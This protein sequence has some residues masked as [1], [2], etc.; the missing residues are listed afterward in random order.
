MALPQI[1]LHTLAFVMVVAAIGNVRG[2]EPAGSSQDPVLPDLTEMTPEQ[3]TA[4]MDRYKRAMADAQQKLISRVTAEQKERM[5]QGSHPSDK[6]P[7]EPPIPQMGPNYDWELDAK[8]QGLDDDVRARLCRDSL[9]IAGQE[10]KQSFS[11]YD[12]ASAIP[13]VTSD[14]L[15]NGFHVLLEAT[16]K[17]FEV[18]RAVELREALESTWLGIDRS[19]AEERVPP[20]L[21][22]PYSRHLARVIGP[23][24]RL[25]GSSIA[26][27]DKATESDIDE[28]V[29]KITAAKSAELPGWMAPAEPALMAIDFRRCRPLGFYADLP[30]LADYYRAVRW[31][32]LVPLRAGRDNEAGAAALAVTAIRNSP[33]NL[34]EFVER[35]VKVWGREDKT[36][37]S[38]SEQGWPEFLR[39]IVKDGN[40]VQAVQEARRRIVDLAKGTKQEVNDRVRLPAGEEADPAVNLLAPTVLPDSQFLVSIAGS[41]PGDRLRPQGLEVAAWLGSD[42]A[43]DMLVQTSGAKL[44]EAIRA[45]RQGPTDQ[46]YWNATVPE[47]YYDV[48]RAVFAPPD[49]AAPPFM[50]SEAWHRKSTQT[51]LAGWAQLR[52]AWELQSEL[53]VYA[54]CAFDRPSGLVEPSPLFFRKMNSLE[55]MLVKRFQEA[56]VFVDT[57]DD[58]IE[59]LSDGLRT[60][61]RIGAGKV[62][63][64]MD[65]GR[66]DDMEKVF[67]LSLI[68]HDSDA[69][70]EVDRADE[71]HGETQKQ[72][73]S[74][75]IAVLSNRI[76]RLKKGERLPPVEEHWRK[77]D[78][79]QQLFERWQ[80]LQRL[81]GR[82][83]VMVQKQLRGADWDKDE[84]ELLKD[85]GSELKEIMGYFTNVSGMEQ[86]DAPRWTTVY[87]DMAANRNLAVA[88]GRPRALYVLYPWKGKPVLCRGAVMTY[89]EY[90]SEGRLTDLEWKKLLDSPAAPAQPEWLQ[91]LILPVPQ[92]R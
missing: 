88:I 82:L 48:L 20:Q 78:P 2:A 84:A 67:E 79:D 57:P 14:S 34:R 1:W 61:K 73:Y 40:S 19:L 87:Q 60:L 58:E 37:V 10:C 8:N 64:A 30:L 90:L 86:D 11:V 27:G 52:H 66:M 28:T 5:R 23:A 77:R 71:L 89:Y 6:R 69:S 45:R 63:L 59:Y 41:R 26:L 3:A 75:V 92:E 42:F 35:G 55:A 13:F 39:Q 70:I 12:G 47:Y 25:L 50:N 18:R 68:A 4:A 7:V 43:L 9:V 76:D 29:Q 53:I 72:Y 17:R 38:S 51:A 46:V 81:T 54:A 44:A 16:L 36:T 85:Y 62:E 65:L 22:A 15:L 33:Q 31:L 32:Q 49:S 21:V 80:S 24:L 56:R 74:R 83:E 91:P